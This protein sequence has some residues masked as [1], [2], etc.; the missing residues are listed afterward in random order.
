[1]NTLLTATRFALL[2][3]LATALCSCGPS[4]YSRSEMNPRKEAMYRYA[5]SLC[6][7][8]T[9]AS[10]MGVGGPSHPARLKEPYPTQVEMEAVIG[11]ADFSQMET[12]SDLH[13]LSGAGPLLTAYWWERDSTWVVPGLH[14]K[15]FREIIIARFD[16]DGRLRMLEV[17][18]P[19]GFELVGRSSYE[20]HWI[21]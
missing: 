17:L 4:G 19:Y 7:V 21:E 15:G 5:S 10:V 11:K 8:D 16:Q 20:W 18:K 12:V 14:K 1:M 13:P 3:T 6:V 2:A 9:E